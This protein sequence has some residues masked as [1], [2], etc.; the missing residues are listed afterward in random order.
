MASTDSSDTK[1]T[2][3]SQNDVPSKVKLMIHHRFPGV[4][5]M[6]PIYTGDGA[7]CYSSPDQKV[8]AGSTM[9]VDFNIDPDQDE[10]I[11][12]LMY[13]LQRKNANQSND[14]IIFNGNE[15]PYTQ[16]FIIWKVNNS[17]EFCMVSDLIEYDK[18]HVWNR[19]ELMRLAKCYE[20]YDI[21]HGPIEKT[22]LMRDNAVFMTRVNV[23]REEECYKLEITISET[24][25]RDDTWRPQYIDVDR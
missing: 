21:Q 7:T 11:G 8:D 1:S 2:Q 20:L 12:V 19:I 24:G 22:Y 9:Q 23:T 25:I 5:L 10:S 16:L 17:K 6:S 13:K 14:T 4:E 3:S 15:A 18:G